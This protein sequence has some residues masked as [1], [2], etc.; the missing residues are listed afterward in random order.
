VEPQLVQ[1]LRA[2]AVVA[3][4]GLE[5]QR[6]VGGDVSWPWSWSW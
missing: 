1:D 6:L 4:V 3:L 2:D 5:A